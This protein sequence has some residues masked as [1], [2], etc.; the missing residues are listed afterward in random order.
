ML[1][2]FVHPEKGVTSTLLMESGKQ[3]W[4]RLEERNSNEPCLS[5]PAP[6]AFTGIDNE[7]IEVRLEAREQAERGQR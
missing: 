5:Y 7:D 1:I 2:H 6:G 3:V 4:T